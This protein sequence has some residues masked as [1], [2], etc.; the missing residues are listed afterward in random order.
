MA[1]GRYKEQLSEPG[2]MRLSDGYHKELMEHGVP[3]DYRAL[4]ALKGSALVLDV[5]T[6]LAHRLHRI[7][8]KRVRPP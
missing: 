2:V 3:L 1:G 4:H 5:Y 7:E 6:W 8:G